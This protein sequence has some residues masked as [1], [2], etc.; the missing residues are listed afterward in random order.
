MP[1]YRVH[2]ERFVYRLTWPV[3]LP[4]YVRA[5]T[6]PITGHNRHKLLS[7]RLSVDRY[8]TGMS[9]HGQPRS[10]RERLV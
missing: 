7:A 4:D 3:M 6:W 1:P 8:R 9:A 5:D 2:H 10:I